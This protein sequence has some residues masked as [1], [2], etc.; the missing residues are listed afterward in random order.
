M[1]AEGGTKA[2]VA[3]LAANTG[4]AISKFVAAAITGSASM[5]AEGVHSVADAANQVLLLI[6][7]KASRKAASPA[8]PFG[9][10]RERYI[11][12][13]IVSIVL[14]SIG[15]VYALY[16][17]WHKLQDTGHGLES[18]L[19]AVVVLLV[20]ITLESFSLRTA[21]KESNAVRG[22]QSWVQFIKGSRSPELPVILLEDIG[23]LVGLVL[24]LLG[25]G[26]TWIT[27]NGLFDAL[28]T[29]SIG[30]LLV[31][32]AVVLAI[33]IR[34]MLI[35][36][37]ATAE[38][39]AAIEDAIKQDGTSALIHLKTLHVGPDELLV[40][41]KV[42]IDRSETGAQVAAEIDAAE[43]RIRAAV[44]KAKLIYIEPDIRRTGA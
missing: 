20:A 8:H 2:I 32:I 14:F 39:I 30:V 17:G 42:G 1:S 16:E 4:I 35:G 5:L 21:V 44:P 24:A 26:L 19:V 23:A 41:A 40:A 12:A 29:M 38:D 37:S 18:P 13:F 9:Y 6:G 25:V 7:G 3:A 10:G 34:S 27:H 22:K 11:Y 15:G 31:C 43:A 28:G 36:E 33:E